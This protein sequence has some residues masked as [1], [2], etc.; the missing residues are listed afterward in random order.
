MKFHFANFYYLQGWISKYNH[1]YYA[2]AH[3]HNYCDDGDVDAGDDNDVDHDNDFDDNNVHGN[4][5]ININNKIIII[6]IIIIEII[7]IMLKLIKQIIYIDNL[8]IFN[9]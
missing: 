5:I 4:M 1:N 7:K 9:L 2:A 6:I 8:L 3:H